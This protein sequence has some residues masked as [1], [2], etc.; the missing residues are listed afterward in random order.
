M[1]NG[2]RV[3]VEEGEKFRSWMMVMVAQECEHTCCCRTVQLNMVTIV[4]L[5][6]H[7]STTIK[8]SFLKSTANLPFP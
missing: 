8:K 1:F 3:S 2:D 5:I 6:I 7:D 4:C